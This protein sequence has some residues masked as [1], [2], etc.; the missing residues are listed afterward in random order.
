MRPNPKEQRLNL[1][2]T[3]AAYVAAAVWL[4]TQI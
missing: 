4:I 3:V 1:I 2:I